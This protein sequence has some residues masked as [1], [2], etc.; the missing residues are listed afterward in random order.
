MVDKPEA[1]VKQHRPID[2][3]S[4]TIGTRSA[5]AGNS[6]YRLVFYAFH[7]YELVR[8]DPF[9]KGWD[10]LRVLN[11]C[12]DQRRAL[13]SSWSI[14]GDWIQRTTLLWSAFLVEGDSSFLTIRSNLAPW[15]QRTEYSLRRVA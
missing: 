14:R 2:H 5:L 13:Y 1:P 3:L 10:C 8:Y 12:E 11:C 15:A 9:T 6:G 4:A 7:L